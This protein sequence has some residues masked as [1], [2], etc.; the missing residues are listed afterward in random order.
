M[1]NLSSFLGGSV[2]KVNYITTVTTPQTFTKPSNVSW[3]Q[4]LL[5]GGGGSVGLNGS[6]GG[7]GQ[8]LYLPMY[9]TGNS[10]ITVGAAG[11]NTTATNNGPTTYTALAGSNG[12][13]P[14]GGNGGGSW[15]SY[16]GSSPYTQLIA[17]GKGSNDSSYPGN[18]G[19]GAGG[20]WSGGGG[21]FNDG[22]FSSLGGVCT[23][24]GAVPN[25]VSG[26]SFGLTGN[27]SGAGS[28]SGLA[29]IFYMG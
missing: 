12:S 17:S 9:L 2:P 10:S 27:N 6:G 11:A 16:S 14:G 19:L 20:A 5:V 28:C 13:N 8:I 24:S 1:S 25:T 3:V 4:V 21:G 7:G 22:S 15:A 18:P 26:G 23:F 29:I